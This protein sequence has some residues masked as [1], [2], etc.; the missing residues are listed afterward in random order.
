MVGVGTS[1]GVAVILAS[2][3]GVLLWKK[4]AKKSV[5][6]LALFAGLFGS[7]TVVGWLGA[8]ATS[9]ILGVGILTLI[10]IVGGVIFWHEAVKLNG[11]HQYRTPVI[12][13]AVGVALTASFGGVQH[14][15]QHGTTQLTSFVNQH[16][17]GR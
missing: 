4:K 6:W 10:V 16:T 8:F 14:A 12:G 3:A 1:A 2:L 15:V 13:F 9:R 17:T 5:A 11:H 7:Y